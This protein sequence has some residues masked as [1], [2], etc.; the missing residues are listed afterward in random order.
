MRRQVCSS[1]KLFWVEWW[2]LTKWPYV[3]VETRE[4]ATP[5]QIHPFIRFAAAAGDRVDICVLSG[6]AWQTD[7][8][9]V[10]WP[11]K[12][13]IKFGVADVSIK[14]LYSEVFFWVQFSA[15]CLL[16]SLSL[17]AALIGPMGLKL[18]C[19]LDHLASVYYIP[20]SK[21]R[22]ALITNTREGPETIPIPQFTY[23]YAS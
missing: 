2:P 6:E 18:G 15:V 11:N 4:H 10:V 19:I 13:S 17:S 3:Y 23:L 1:K 8:E 12:Y 22:I 20:F 21:K 14:R 9:R 5:L 7:G 16:N